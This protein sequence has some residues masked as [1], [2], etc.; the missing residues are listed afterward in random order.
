MSRSAHMKATREWR[1]K[2]PANV[3]ARKVRATIAAEERRQLRKDNPVEGRFQDALVAA[4]A[5]LARDR[6]VP[7]VGVPPGKSRALPTSLAAPFIARA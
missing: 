5:A 7:F 1:K 3:H 2:L 4:R 6:G